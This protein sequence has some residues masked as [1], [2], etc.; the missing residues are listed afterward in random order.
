MSFAM[1]LDMLVFVA[2]VVAI[3]FYVKKKGMRLKAMI[4]AVPVNNAKVDTNVADVFAR[5]SQIAFY[6]TET[7]QLQFL[8]NPAAAAVSG[9][10]MQA[11]QFV[12]D[13]KAD[14][15]IAVR[16]GSNAVK[17]LNKAQITIYEATA[18]SLERNL[19]LLEAKQLE[20]LTHI[21][22]SRD[23]VVQ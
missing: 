22:P 4:I 13:Q 16:C 8:P 17:V 9:A 6:D 5:A 18:D 7:K 3:K 19:E 20:P 1:E 11:V 21:C 12:I 2:T 10:G 14:A 15:L 23:E